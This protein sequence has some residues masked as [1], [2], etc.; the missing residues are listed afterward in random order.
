MH[1]GAQ[2]VPPSLIRHWLE[3]FPHHKYDTN[4][5]LSESTGPGC[6]HLGM[7]NIHKVGAIGV[8]GFGWKCKIVD[9]NGKPVSQ[10][11]NNWIIGAPINVYYDYRN[12][13]IYQYDDFDYSLDALGNIVIRELLPTVDTDGDGIPDAAL[14]R[15]DA[16]K[17]GSAKISDVN[18]DGKISIDDRVV[19]NR[20]PDFTL[21][22]SSRVSW[23]NLDLYLDM[24]ASVGGYILNPLLY[25]EEYGGNL[26]G[27]FNG[28]KVDY[29]TPYNPVNAFPRPMKNAEIPYLRTYAYQDASYFKLRTNLA[30]HSPPNLYPGWVSRVCAPMQRPQTFSQSPRCCL[31]APRS[32]H[33]LIPRQKSSF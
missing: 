32:W 1:I 21:S 12:E 22:L 6:V 13:G 28:C 8:P 33:R 7:E 30:T 20:D 2:P 27:S 23:K 18:G 17:P 19:Y 11:G 25:H 15:D 9:E 29:W 3:Y 26:R 10:P 4:Y 5:G 14:D 16:V 24:Y 31:T